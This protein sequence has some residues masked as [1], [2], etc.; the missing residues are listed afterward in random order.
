MTQVWNSTNRYGAVAIA[1]H[2]IGAAGVIWMY[3]LGEAVEHAK[4]DELGREAIIAAIRLHVSVGMVFFAF[5]VA[6]IL[7]HI[8]QKQPRPLSPHRVLSPL[9]RAVQWGFLAMISVQI[10]TGPMVVWSSGRPIA[11]FQTVFIPSPMARIEWL[12]EAL[13]TVHA[14]APNLFWPLL[15]LHVAGALKHTLFDRDPTLI[16]MLRP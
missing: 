12:H 3:F 14:L 9:A 15:V 4:A 11:I 5:L 1:L 6:R 7:S 13:E 8:A 10:L 2:W 16:R